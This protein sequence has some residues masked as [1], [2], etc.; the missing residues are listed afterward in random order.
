MIRWRRRRLRLRRR[1]RQVFLQAGVT[2]LPQAAS[3]RPEAAEARRA[4]R[5]P[6]YYYLNRAPGPCNNTHLL[7]SHLAARGGVHATYYAWPSAAAAAGAAGPAVPAPVGLSSEARKHAAGVGAPDA[8]TGVAAFA[9][10]ADIDP[11]LGGGGGYA[12]RW[13]GILYAPS[14]SRCG[15]ARPETGELAT[16]LQRSSLDA[17]PFPCNG[18]WCARVP[19]RRRA[20]R[21]LKRNARGAIRP[22]W[23]DGRSIAARG[24]VFTSRVACARGRKFQWG[25]TGGMDAA[26]RVRLWVDNYLVIDQWTSLDT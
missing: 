7:W 2:S 12:V 11:A 16:V 17:Q 6:A 24:A 20:A 19:P 21:Y 25:G 26:D 14:I 8:A 4:G 5:H 23:G 10:P 9:A 1:R 3:A 15:P 13:A 18:K 22:C